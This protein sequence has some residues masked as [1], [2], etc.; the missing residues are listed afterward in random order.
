MDE[1][2]KRKL[3][4]LADPARTHA[5][6]AADSKQARD[7]AIYEAWCARHSLR[8]IADACNLSVS[9][10]HRVVVAKTAEAQLIHVED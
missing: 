2:T 1:A 7:Q 8:S 3:A 6:L 5:Q 4:R 9:Q 10:V